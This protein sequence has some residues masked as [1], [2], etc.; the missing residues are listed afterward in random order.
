MALLKVSMVSRVGGVSGLVEHGA[1]FATEA[2]H[3]KVHSGL[4]QREDG[5]LGV[6]VLDTLSKGLQGWIRKVY[7]SSLIT[8]LIGALRVESLQDKVFVEL[9]GHVSGQLGIL[10]LGSSRHSGGVGHSEEDSGEEL[11]ES[12]HRDVPRGEGRGCVEWE[13]RDCFLHDLPQLSL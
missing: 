3:S 9:T 11:V 5:T 8:N 12:G 4:L 6:G 2:G 10:G 1:L 7:A 13:A